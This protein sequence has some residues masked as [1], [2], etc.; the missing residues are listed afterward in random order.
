MIT[1]KELILKYLQDG[2]KI[3]PLEALNK[4][5]CFRLGAVIFT[6]KQD[7]WDIETKMVANGRKHFA[8]YEL[9]SLKLNKSNQFEFCIKS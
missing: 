7:G 5:G 6:L 9:K 3:T 8:Q 4:F 1:Q 2:N